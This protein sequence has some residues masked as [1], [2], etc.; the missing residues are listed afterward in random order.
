MEEKIR[1]ILSAYGAENARRINQKAD[2]A[3]YDCGEFVLRIYQR[4]VA[5]YA[6]LAGKELPG[7]PKVYEYRQ[8]REQI[9]DH[10]QEPGQ[11]LYVAKRSISTES[12]CRR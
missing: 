10:D 1:E 5:A 2:A 7:I 6:L 11:P 9:Q 8:W 3:V 12:A 4:D